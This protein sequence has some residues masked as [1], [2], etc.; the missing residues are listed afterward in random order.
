[1]KTTVYC[2]TN[3]K[4][5]HS[6]YLVFGG[7]EFFLFNQAYRKGVD[8]FYG[9][10]VPFDEALKHSRAKH[11]AAISRTMDKIPIYVKYIEKEFDV[12]VLNRTKRRNAQKSKLSCA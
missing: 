8:G 7:K 12:E 1:M 6:F 10:G 4:G 11:D 9:N 5:I 3:A 2:K